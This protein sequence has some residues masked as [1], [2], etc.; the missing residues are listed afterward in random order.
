M[1]AGKRCCQECGTVYDENDTHFPMRDGV[2]SV[3]CVGCLEAAREKRQLRNR[4]SRKARAAKMKEMEAVAVSSMLTNAVRGGTNIPHSAELLEQLMAYFGGVSGFSALLV[5]QYFDAKPGSTQRG[6]A[7]EMV[8]RLV[9]KN[10]DQGG[11]Q[12]PLSLW[13][14]E[15]LESELNDRLKTAVMKGRMV[16]GETEDDPADSDASAPSESHLPV[17]TLSVEGSPIRV[18]GAEDRGAEAVPPDAPAGSDAP[19]PGE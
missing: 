17:R 16:D 12:K 7:M 19:V 1:E 6:R 3:A 9:Q 13:S 8:V 5:K 15:E 18:S 10:V 11:A 2:L 14:E 4:Q